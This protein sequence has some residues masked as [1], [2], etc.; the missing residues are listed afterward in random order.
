M[1]SLEE[2]IQKAPD[3]I[4][5]VNALLVMDE[6]LCCCKKALCAVSGGSDSDI[7]MDLCVS[8]DQDKKVT[9]AFYDTGL[10]FQATKDHIRYL[11]NRYGVKIHV[12]RAVKPIPICCRKFGVP[13][14]SKRISDYISRLQSHEFQWE[15]KP[16]EELYA[17]YP[18]CKTAL[19]WWCNA[20]G[21]GSQFNIERHAWLKEF[22]IENPPT[23][24]ISN[25]CCYYAKKKV[26]KQITEKGDYDLN[27]TGI[28]R[29]E[30]GVRATAYKNCFSPATDNT[31]AQYRPLF[32]FKQDTKRQYEEHYGIRHSACYEAWG[33]KRTGCSGCPFAKD[34]ESELAATEKYEPKLY[35][36][37][38]KVFGASYAYTRQYRAFQAKMNE[39]KTSL[40]KTSRQKCV[41]TDFAPVT[42]GGDADAIH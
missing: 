16:F 21:S 3:N 8:L 33:L 4:E 12:E 35:K 41:K 37:L 14:L 5:I 42:K 11:E 6:K 31:I 1:K 30:G 2:V 26:A 25:K 10:E 24:K 17:K 22:L 15:D 9:Y 34:F 23:F 13:F 18:K 40:Q 36:A 29:A 27:I 38:N 20:W 7:V 39:T 19:M 32:W 28:R